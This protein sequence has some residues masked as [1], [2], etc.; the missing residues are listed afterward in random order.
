[1]IAQKLNEFE[2]LKVEDESHKSLKEQL[3]TLRE[4]WEKQSAGSTVEV[5]KEKNADAE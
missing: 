5:L 2:E 4:W 3:E 1:M